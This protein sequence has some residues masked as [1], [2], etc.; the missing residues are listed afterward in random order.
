MDIPRDYNHEL[1]AFKGYNLL[2][3]KN[4]TKSRMAMY[5]KN[6]INYVRRDDLEGHGNGLVVIDVKLKST[7]RLIGVYRIF[8]PPDLNK[9]IL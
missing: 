1:L 3:E 4:D 6:G 7:W 5:V 2:I 9:L 8:N